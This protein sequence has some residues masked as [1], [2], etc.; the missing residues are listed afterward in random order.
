MEF[1]KI[2]EAYHRM[3]KREN[4]ATSENWELLSKLIKI[5]PTVNAQLKKWNNLTQ[6]DKSWSLVPS[7][8]E[9]TTPFKKLIMFLTGP[10]N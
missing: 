8:F 3:L 5:M 1:L 4:L 6:N 9:W 10:E 2:E 7:F